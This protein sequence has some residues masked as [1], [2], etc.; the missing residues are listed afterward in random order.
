MA[1]EVDITLEKIKKLVEDIS[2]KVAPDTQGS[3]STAL[4][5]Q[6]VIPEVVKRTISAVAVRGSGQQSGA[7]VPSSG[8][9]QRQQQSGVNQQENEFLRALLLKILMAMAQ[10]QQGGSLAGGGVPLIGRQKI[11]GLLGQDT[12]LP[13]L[14][15]SS[16]STP[17]VD[18]S[19]EADNPGMWGRLKRMFGRGARFAGDAV[20]HPNYGD[21]E[22]LSAYGNK[23][24]GRGAPIAGRLMAGAGGMMKGMQDQSELSGAGS[25][26]GGLGKMAG[27]IPVVGKPIEAATKF[28]DVL[29]KSVDRLKKWNEEL[30]EGNMQFAEFSGSMAQVQVEQMQRDIKLSQERGERRADSARYLAEGKSGLQQRTSKVEDFF[31]NMKNYVGGFLSKFTTNLIDM[32]TLNSLKGES[33]KGGG[34][35]NINE[36]VEYTARTAWYESYGRPKRWQ[37]DPWDPRNQFKQ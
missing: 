18:P 25:F 16:T 6:N 28:A 32:L 29:F 3:T 8:G 12:S 14:N 21:P 33:A 2:K 7:L 17:R 35:L 19:T 27:G 26:L 30:H 5:V 20:N 37:D 1:E 13:K 9:L 36:W 24:A 11:A 22:G 4:V 15:V 31:A 34:E 10:A 23:I